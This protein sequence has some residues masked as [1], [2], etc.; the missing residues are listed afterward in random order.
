MYKRVFELTLLILSVVAY[1]NA[2]IDTTAE[3]DTTIVL[4]ADFTADS[5][6]DSIFCHITGESWKKPLL[7]TYKIINKDKV[8]FS[9]TY[10]NDSFDKE[11]SNSEALDWCDE[12]YLLCKEK[13]YFG[14]MQEKLIKTVKLNDRRRKRL[15]DTTS[16]RSIL[17]IMEQLYIDSLGYSKDKAA[18]KAKNLTA[19]LKKR[20]FSC[21]VLPLHPLYASFPMLYDPQSKKFITLLGF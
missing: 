11:F 14:I 3:V 7:V 15:F 12:E 8:I 6:N 21:L 17:R 9:K 4:T 1:S 10:N 19:N 13:W 5:I 16:E 18:S 20:N 2:E